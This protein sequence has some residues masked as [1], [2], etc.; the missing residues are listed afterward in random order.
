VMVGFA[1]ILLFLATGTA[2]SEA[3]VLAYGKRLD[4]NRIDSRL[5][6]E[7]FQSWMERT[8]GRSATVTWRSDDCGEGGGNNSPLCITAKA[9][10]R[11]RGSVVLSIAIGSVQGGFGG[12]PTLFFGIIEGLG[13]SELL[14]GE[15]LPLLTSKIRAARALDAELSQLPEV[16]FSPMIFS[17]RTTRPSLNVEGRL[18]CRSAIARPVDAP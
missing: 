13:P 4:V 14:E 7:L 2:P 3:D 18:V 17:C 6:S 1:V 12:K 5:G 8:L 15:D 10:L 16:Y 11:P 9:R